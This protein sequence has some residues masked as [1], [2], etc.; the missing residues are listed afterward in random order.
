MSVSG[1]S[2]GS[3]TDAINLGITINTGK[4][5][6]FPSLSPDGKYLFFTRWVA[7]GNEDVMWVSAEIINRIRK[8]IVK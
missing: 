8:K 4:Q 2:D 1:E 5:E 6:R 3:W 7:P